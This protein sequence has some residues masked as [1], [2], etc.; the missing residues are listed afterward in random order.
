MI[1]IEGM[2]TEFGK[3]PMADLP[4]LDPNSKIALLGKF[5]KQCR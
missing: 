4:Y 5:C 1:I 3:M 2:G